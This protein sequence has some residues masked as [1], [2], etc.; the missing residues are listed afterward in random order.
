MADQDK[1]TTPSEATLQAEEDEARAEHK[2]DRPPTAEEEQAAPSSVSDNTEKSF[3][4]MA[5]LGAEDKG[6]GRLP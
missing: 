5:K 6:E 4:E 2:A 3:E 1:G